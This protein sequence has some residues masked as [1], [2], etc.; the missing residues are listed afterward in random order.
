MIVNKNNERTKEGGKKER[1]KGGKRWYEK[2]EREL[3][4]VERKRNKKWQKRIRT[5]VK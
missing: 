4:V 1:T 5:R 3:G 2:K